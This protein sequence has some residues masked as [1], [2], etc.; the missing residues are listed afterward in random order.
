MK[1]IDLE[2]VKDGEKYRLNN[3]SIT[4][5]VLTVDS[6]NV[7]GLDYKY[8][9]E[10][11][12]GING[13]FSTSKRTDA[14]KGTLL[15]S[16]NVNKIS[17]A[18]HLKI[19]LATLLSGEFFIRELAPSEIEIPFQRIGERNFNFEPNY[20]SGRTIKMQLTAPISFD[21]TE[22]NG[23]I[24]ILFETVDLPYYQSVGRSLDLESGRQ[25]SLWSSDML[26]DWETNS[27]S[28][29][30]TFENIR[31]GNVY[32]HGTAP[33][34][35]FNQDCTVTITLSESTDE[36]NWYLTKSDMMEIKGL[37]LKGGD[38]IKFDGLQTFRNG[39]PIN[40][41]TRLN[42]PKL[43]P[44]INTFNFSQRVEKVVFDL[45]FYYL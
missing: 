4:G 39:Q 18:E 6:F 43:Q 13:R 36:F 16:Y 37:N 22:L 34:E 23:Q 30:Y 35:Q 7:D 19:K 21:V 27:A 9:Y 31:T 2:I 24:E 17:S 45:K 42:F 32:Y 41:Y 12:D 8:T 28:R 1:V 26:L 40:E 29:K 15:V 38:V 14:R 20:V 33:I 25:S 11:I 10:N 3:N 44:G 5:D